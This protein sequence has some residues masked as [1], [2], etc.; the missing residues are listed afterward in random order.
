[1]ETRDTRNALPR[2][3]KIIRLIVLILLVAA[4]IT[5]AILL[6]TTETGKQ[7]LDDPR[8]A[9]ADVRSWVE[10]H[11][12]AAPL[13][14]IGLYVLLVLLM[15]P[16]WWLQILS[17]IGFGLVW[18]VLFSQIGATI[19]ATGALLLSR[20][21]MGEWFHSNVEGRLK[22]LRDLDEKMGH[23]G[24]LVVMGVRLVHFMPIGLTN[25][26][27]GLTQITVID[28]ILGTML[29]GLPTVAVWVG[30]GAGLHPW[31]NWRFLGVLIAMNVILLVPLILRYTRP[32]WFKKYGIE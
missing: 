20:W 6:F 21:L 2:Y 15:L 22:R 26:L 16:V 24:L 5:A 29:G 7:I 13:A 25:Y 11:R 32:Q 4:I 31:H 17:G 18:G 12:L 27:F 14:Y 10:Q 19:G 3:A 30:T 8:K 1:L 9:G 28:V 23:N